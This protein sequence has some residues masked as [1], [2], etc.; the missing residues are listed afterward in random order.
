MANLSMAGNNFSRSRLLS[1][2]IQLLLHKGFNTLFYSFLSAP[3]ESLDSQYL[4][5]PEMSVSH[6]TCAYI[7]Q[8]M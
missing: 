5:V 6:L 3:M 1:A 8:C 2:Y 4:V 7:R